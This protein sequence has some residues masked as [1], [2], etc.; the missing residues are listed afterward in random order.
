[1]EFFL[2]DHI[3]F[4]SNQRRTY[5]TI[6]MIKQFHLSH[7]QTSFLILKTSSTAE[8]DNPV[9]SFMDELTKSVKNRHNRYNIFIANAT[10]RNESLRKSE[11]LVILKNYMDCTYFSKKPNNVAERYDRT[12]CISYIYF[13][14]VCFRLK[15]C[16]LLLHQE[17]PFHTQPQTCNWFSAYYYV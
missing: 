10:N 16:L 6:N 7:V 1:M 2:T 17:M 11:N 8:L 5:F 15:R 12:I 4:H 9:I 14:G 3:L 13:L